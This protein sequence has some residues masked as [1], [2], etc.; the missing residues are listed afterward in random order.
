MQDPGAFIYAARF[1]GG[2]AGGAGVFHGELISGR[3]RALALRLPRRFPSALRRGPAK[4]PANPVWPANAPPSINKHKSAR[5]GETGQ[6]VTV[7]R[8]K[9]V[10]EE[11]Q[12]RLHQGQQL[13]T[14][15]DLSCWRAEGVERGK[16]GFWE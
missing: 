2:E 12:T 11:R 4:T 8:F 14:I 10:Q 9:R 5:G 13:P 1:R 7:S 3:D 16:R 15:L 6:C